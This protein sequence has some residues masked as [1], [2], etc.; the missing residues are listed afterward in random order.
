MSW[1]GDKLGGVFGGG[2]GDRELRAYTKRAAVIGQLSDEM[3]ALNDAALRARFDD[4]R[5]RRQ[6]GA[7]ADALMNETFAVTREA[8]WRQLNMRHFDV[9]LVGGMA[10]FD[11]KI[12]EMKT[13]EGKTLVA[14]L[15]ACLEALSGR[16]VHVVTVNDYLA[17]RDAEWMGKLYEF[18][19]LS[20]GVNVPGLNEEQKRAAYAADI[21]YGTNNEFGFDYLRH[22]MRY[23]VDGIQR[24][25]NY[26]IV[27]E[28]DSI[29]IDEARTPLIISGESNE[30]V[31]LYGQVAAIA[32]DFKRGEA[33]A[34]DPENPS[35]DFVVDEKHRTVQLTDRGFERAEKLFAQAGL[36]AAGDSLYE[37]ERLPLLHHLD[38]ALRARHLFFRDKDYVV[39][40][41]KVVIVDEFTG[42]LMHGRRWGDNQHQAVE[43]KEG[44][45]VQKENQTLASIS[46]QNY[47]RLYDKLAGM[48][49]TA[50]TEAEEFEFIYGLQT[51]VA[52]PHKPMARDDQ[53]DKVYRTAAGK[54]KAI[55][56]DIAAS[57]ARGQPVLV[58][59]TS[60]EASERLSEALTA[61]SVAHNV[62][63]AKH[64]ESEAGVISQAG[65]PQAIT[66]ATN[67]AGRGTD[68]VLGGNIGGELARIGADEALDD[69]QKQAA[70][71][72]AQAK[73]QTAHDAVVA[74]GG[75]RVI[76]TERHES[77]R[78]DNQ[79]RG[80]A[81]RQGD[82]GASIFYLSFDDSLLRVF[83]TR[84]VSALMEKM[85]I[86][87]DEA[88][89]AGM[90]SRTIEGA[91]RKVEAQNFDVRRQLL[92]YDDIANDQR[93]I[94]YNQ[95]EEILRAD[96]IA[97][98]AKQFRVEH[99]TAL[100][101]EFVPAEQPEEQWRAADLRAK[102]A[103]EYAVDAAVDDWIAAE[104][105]QPRDYFLGKLVAAAEAQFDA[106]LEGVQAA[107]LAE[108]MRR[109]ILNVI[110]DHWRGHL[111]ALDSLRQS[112]GFRGM[113][114]KNPKQEYKR[115]A[116][117]MFEQLLQTVQKTIARVLFVLRIKPREEAPPPPVMPAF[118]SAPPLAPPAAPA[119]PASPLAAM[120]RP[121][122]AAPPVAAGAAPGRADPRALRSGAPPPPPRRMTVQVKSGAD[123]VGRN[124]PC[125]CGSGKKYKRCCGKI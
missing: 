31:E 101:D 60:I 25:L 52:P 65:L 69:A 104:D 119:S 48:T 32:R 77:R 96:D 63:N 22:N 9:Q 16:G 36:T 109:L 27:D 74:A 89:E 92:D 83:A 107:P 17:R 103:K 12:A 82:P 90:V 4:L 19:G 33:N 95:R 15:A 66:I 125:P 70:A 21:L 93:H 78:I 72:A 18:L 88:I 85:K 61:A 39:Q 106:K 86:E 29:L 81:G 11:G 120:L 8:A 26:A 98:V 49:G 56:D 111:T 102:L 122:A 41:G 84:H 97:A 40:D 2:G 47:F 51:L 44:L 50:K 24:Q 42:R 80:R 5:A 99:L 59:T 57:R 73:W 71:A 116:F 108:F 1:L 35:G 87:E 28:V 62:L 20:V 6:N 75:L 54:H 79:L 68:I 30:S 105:K 76:G 118:R 124:A 91:Q 37:S 53:L 94:I 64:H 114:Q 100:M 3:T 58:G 34:R 14:T 13:G 45:A 113:A 110:D 23:T 115:E 121:P 38:V 112:I 10:L 7:D 117:E 67:M 123:K 55:M 43:A 46:F